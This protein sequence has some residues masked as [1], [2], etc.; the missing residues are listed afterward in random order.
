MTASHCVGFTFPGMI[1]EPEEGSSGKGRRGKKSK[2]WRMVRRVSIFCRVSYCGSTTPSPPLHPLPH[3]RLPPPRPPPIY[4]LFTTH[5]PLPPP[6]LLPI[7]PLPP[8][9]L[10]PPS[11]PLVPSPRCRY[12]YRRLDVPGSFSGR[13]ISPRPHRGPDP[14]NLMSLAI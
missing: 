12:R 3:P 2:T 8:P 11:R 7:F 14:R 5:L 4:H 6:L 13:L 10:T 9:L 1:E